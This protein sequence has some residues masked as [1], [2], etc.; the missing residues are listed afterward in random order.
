M[1]KKLNFYA[2]AELLVRGKK[3]TFKLIDIIALYIEINEQTL[4]PYALKIMVKV[5][6]FRQR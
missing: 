2:I 5:V 4:Y 3:L 1:Y 6:R